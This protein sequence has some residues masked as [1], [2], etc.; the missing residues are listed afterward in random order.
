MAVSAEFTADFTQFIGAAK[1]AEAAITG[2]VQTSAQIGTDTP[3]HAQAAGAA[4]RDF[5]G[6]AKDFATEYIAAFAEEEAAT[7]RLKSAITASGQSASDVLPKYQAM[8]TQ[9]QTLTRYSDD[10][11]TSAQTTFTQIA[12]LGPEQMQP[13]V[14]AA[15]NLAAGLGIGLEEAARKIATVIGTDGAKLGTLKALLGDVDLKGKDAA[16]V[17]EIFNS[18]F[19]GAAA[20]DMETSAGKLQ[21]FNNTLDEFK[22]QVGGVLATALTPLLDAFTSLSPPLQTVIAGGTALIAVLVPI[23]VA[24]GTMLTGV[25]ALVTSLGGWAAVSATLTTAIAAIGWPITALIAT[26]TALYLAWKNWDAIVEIVTKVYTAVKTY[27]VDKFTALVGLIKHPIDTIT[28]AFKSMYD[29]VVGHSYVPDMIDGIE[30]QFKRLD[31]AMVKPTQAAAKKV[32]AAVAGITLPGS[33]VGGPQ[34]ARYLESPTGQRVPISDTGSLPDNWWD[35]YSGKS[36]FADVI[37]NLGRPGGIISNVN[38]TQPLGDPAAIARA[39]EDAMN[40]TLR[41]SGVRL[42]SGA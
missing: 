34:G 21:H 41:N 1:D 32:A 9:F 10:A 33:V 42:P 6:K 4:I 8:A 16:Q 24:V 35:V 12:R 5:A 22:G 19:G 31:E 40:R 30:Q 29:A 17:L 26:V 38:I 13:A 37:S 39:V 28:G 3:R 15:A 14:Q 11:V 20:A 27:L 18:K 2:V 25:T 7:N 36:N 23:G